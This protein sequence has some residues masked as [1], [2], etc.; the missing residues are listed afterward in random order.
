[1]LY[2]EITCYLILHINFPYTFK[3]KW[4]NNTCKVFLIVNY[5]NYILCR[6]DR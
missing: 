4:K 5:M 6:I 2:V 3:L 1:M